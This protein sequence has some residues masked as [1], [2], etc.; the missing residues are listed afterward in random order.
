MEHKIHIISQ[1]KEIADSYGL[2][3]THS[4][5][6]MYVFFYKKECG[7]NDPCFAYCIDW[8][9]NMVSIFHLSKTFQL[10]DIMS[11]TR[12]LCEVIA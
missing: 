1:L 11:Y 3:F 6:D 4:D 5:N 7:M 10:K 8:D 2:S 12:L 9:V